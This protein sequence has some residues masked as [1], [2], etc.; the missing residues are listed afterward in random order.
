MSKLSGNAK[1]ALSIGVLAIL[2]LFDGI[3]LNMGSVTMP[4][5]GFVPRIM[6][7]FLLVC[8]AAMFLQEVFFLPLS[9]SSPEKKEPEEGP[10]EAED[11]R[12]PLLLIAA[13]LLYPVA[14]PLLGFLLSTMGL[15]FAG[16]RIFKYR[17][18]QWA[19]VIAVAAT[20]FTYLV[21]EKWLQI[22]FPAGLWG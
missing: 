9:A 5:E 11:T 20:L 21:F 22:L 4:G 16:L 19:C 1:G 6:G 18:W 13:L 14:L 10:P 17:N 12:R 2:Y 3:S 8:C 7:I 15:M